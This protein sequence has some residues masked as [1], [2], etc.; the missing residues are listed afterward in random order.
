MTL[1]DKRVLVIGGGSG[2]GFGIAQGAAKE[3]AQVVIASRDA[4]KIAEA[5]Q[6][7]RASSA[8]I[9]VRD[10]SNV[11]QFFKDHGTFDHIAFT[12]GD[13]DGVVP[14]ALADLDLAK[15]AGGLTTRF[16]GAVAVAKHGATKLPP[17]GS[18]TITNGMLAYKPRKGL[19][20]VTAGACAVEGLALGLAVDLAPVRVNC[21]CPGLIDT[22]IWDAFPE[23]YRERLTAMA[24]KQLVPRPGQPAEAAE[25]YL[26]CMRNSFLTGQ[27]IK[28]EG[29]IALAG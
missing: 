15:A 27:T 20:M 16:W 6:T 11:A 13:W 21:V 4:K 28:I 25:A 18:Y 29:G 23:G 26:T 7:I 12:A 17:D 8:A 19:P 9:D 2:I 10:E 22:E 3:G 14:G 5:A 1:K 24:Q